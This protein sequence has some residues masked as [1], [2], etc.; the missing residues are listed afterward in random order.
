MKED[1]QPVVVK[2]DEVPYEYEYIYLDKYRLLKIR[3]KGS[4]QAFTWKNVD[5]NLGDVI[6]KII[7]KIG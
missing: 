5:F 2:R 7:S 1:W 3:V 4:G 6:Q